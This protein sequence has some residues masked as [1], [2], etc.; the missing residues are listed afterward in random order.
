MALRSWGS[1][2]VASHALKLGGAQSGEFPTEY[3]PLLEPEG[4]EAKG[5]GTRQGCRRPERDQGR[6][7]VGKRS[8][9]SEQPA[10]P[11]ALCPRGRSAHPDGGSP[12]P[13]P[14]PLLRAGRGLGSRWVLAFQKVPWES[15]SAEVTP[16]VEGEAGGGHFRGPI[17]A[18]R[19][20]HN[21]QPPFSPRWDPASAR[22]PRASS[23]PPRQ[24]QLA[25]PP[26]RRGG[27]RG[28]AL[29]PPPGD[30]RGPPRPSLG[31]PAPLGPGP[32]CSPLLLREEGRPPASRDGPRGRWGRGR[33][34][35]CALRARTRL[36]ASLRGDP[37]GRRLR[38]YFI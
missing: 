9:E 32:L 19:A 23:P 35:A 21:E 29:A 34:E 18:A 13:A 12:R 27:G 16:A 5:E 8:S 3:G 25:G 31:R 15:P 33:E 26:F 2:P 22:A 10:A 4:P 14:P 20:R 38:S 28:R 36:P 1:W 24:P 17:P 11:A 7:A 30:S 37:D 6:Q